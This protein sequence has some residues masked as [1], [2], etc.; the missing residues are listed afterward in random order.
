MNILAEEKDGLVREYLQSE[1][2]D[3]RNIALAIKN[4]LFFD[5]KKYF[6]KFFCRI[7]TW[8]IKEGET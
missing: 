7:Y 6:P 5:I 3:S 1:C 4:L 2:K 8:E